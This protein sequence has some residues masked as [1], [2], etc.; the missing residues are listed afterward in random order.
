[1]DKKNS[2]NQKTNIPLLM[3]F[4]FISIFK[5]KVVFDTDQRKISDTS[6]SN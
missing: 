3:L 5:F 1:M 4:Y 6:V 2:C